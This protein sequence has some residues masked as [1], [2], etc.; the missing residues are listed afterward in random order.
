MNM[1]D[2]PALPWIKKVQFANQMNRMVGSDFS[3]MSENPNLKRQL[4]QVWNETD[5]MNSE[6]TRYTYNG[7]NLIAEETF[8]WDG[9]GWVSD[10]RTTYMINQINEVTEILYEV[11]MVDAYVPVDRYVL[12]YG[13]HFGT[14][15]SILDNVIYETWSDPEWVKESKDDYFYF[16]TP[17]EFFPSGWITSFWD[18][19]AWAESEKYEMTA[20]DENLIQIEYGWTDSW[21]P[22]GR[23]VYMETSISEYEEIFSKIEEQLYTYTS[24]P[25]MMAELPDFYTQE[26]DGSVWVFASRTERDVTY[27]FGTGNMLQQKIEMLNWDH[28]EWIPEMAYVVDYD[29]NVKPVKA[30]IDFPMESEYIR[31]TEDVFEYNDQGLLDNAVYRMNTFEELDNVFRRQYEWDGT[32]TSIGDKGEFPDSF[33]LGNAYPNPFNPT[34]VI[35]YE[36][37]VAGQVTIRVY[38]ILGRLVSTLYNGTQAAGKHQVRFDAAGLTSGK[39]LVRMEAPGYTQTRAVTLLK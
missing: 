28:Q 22:I 3:L 35:P 13:Y 11:Y 38:D 21:S 24:L 12:S 34:T 23:T 4:L 29:E 17:T 37:G 30:S 32:G 8:R 36:T 9:T 31:F 2:H 18:G 33:N 15:A 5:W 39:Y 27:D 16:L 26:W 25:L 10:Y 6:E 20:E 14:G 1:P 7:M 19:S